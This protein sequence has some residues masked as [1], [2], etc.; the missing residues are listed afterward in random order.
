MTHVGKL[1]SLVAARVAASISRDL[2]GVEDATCVIVSQIGRPVDD[3][4]I[5][6]LKLVTAADWRSLEAAVTEIVRAELFQLPT[7][8][9]E[10]ISERIAL[11]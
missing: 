2:K 10:L 8:R 6:D 3:P 5:V 4:Q 7:L 11:Y 9:E 1:Y